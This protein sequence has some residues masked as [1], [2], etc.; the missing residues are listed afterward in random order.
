MAFSQPGARSKEDPLPVANRE[1]FR[2]FVTFGHQQSD[3][4]WETLSV[5][6]SITVVDGIA[7]IIVPS[8]PIQEG[9]YRA[10]FEIN[11]VG[12]TVEVQVTSAGTLSISA[13]W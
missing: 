10:V 4:V 5:E 1:V 7:A 8:S 9:S 6:C 12:F 13:Q 2:T 3:A 11:G